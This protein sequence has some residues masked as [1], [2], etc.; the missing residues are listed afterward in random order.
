MLML[1][2]VFKRKYQRSEHL[3]NQR[4]RSKRTFRSEQKW[5]QRSKIK[6]FFSSTHTVVRQEVRFYIFPSFFFGIIKAQSLSY[7]SR[8]LFGY[9][10]Q[11]NIKSKI[12][13]QMTSPFPR[14]RILLGYPVGTTLESKLAST[15]QTIH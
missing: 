4:S 14:C 13:V 10:V 2:Y 12:Q 1:L 6:Q 3:C 9:P 7:P 11:T 5:N 15:I 8:Y